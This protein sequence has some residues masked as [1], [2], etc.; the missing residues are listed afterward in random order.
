MSTLLGPE[1]TARPAPGWGWVVAGRGVRGRG[2]CFGARHHLVHIPFH[3]LAVG[4]VGGVWCG[5]WV[6][7]WSWVENCTVDASILFSVVLLCG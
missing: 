4:L 3:A 7:G 1:G 2:C 5:L 6:V